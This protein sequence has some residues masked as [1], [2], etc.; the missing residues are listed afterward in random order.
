ML[1]IAEGED[2]LK[3]DFYTE[4]NVVGLS[5]SNETSLYWTVGVFA[6]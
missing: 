2:P 6:L 1:N 3:S 5:C 4:N